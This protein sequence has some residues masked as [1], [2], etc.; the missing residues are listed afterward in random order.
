MRRLAVLP[1]LVLLL[2]AAAPAAAQGAVPSTPTPSSTATPAPPPFAPAPAAGKFAVS[3]ERV[4]GA[5]AAVMAFRKVTGLPRTFAASTDVLRRVARGGGAFRVRYPRHGRHVET[6]LSLQVLA[7]IR[8]RRVER[9][10]PI[11]SGKPSTPTVLGTFRVYSKPP[12]TN[13]KGM[14][15]T[16]Y[17]HGGYGIHGYADVP[18]FA[19][20]HGCLRVPVPEAVPIYGWLQFGDIVDVYS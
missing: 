18:A 19:A 11:S 16:S 15:F 8:G 9:I 10:Y 3:L 5:A 7:P 20:S 1:P 2:A 14:V 17:F 13:E 4:N 12:G 6:D